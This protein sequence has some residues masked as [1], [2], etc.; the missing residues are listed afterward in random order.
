MILL[1]LLA[2]R[3]AT[4]A[5]AAPPVDKYVLVDAAHAIDAGR[6]DQARLMVARAVRA[7]F[8]G[9][10]VDK[11]VADISFA[12]GKYEDALGQYKALAASHYQQEQVCEKAALS[13]LQLREFSQAQPFA[14]CATASPTA[15]WRSWNARGVI[16][17]SS[18]DWALAAK[19]YER[20]HAL[21]PGRAEIPNNQGWSFVLQGQWSTALPYFQQ[22]AALD[23]G[24]QRIA[25]NL[26]LT[27]AALSADLPKRRTGESSSDW[28]ARLNDAG[29]TAQLRGDRQRAIAA[30]AQAMYASDGWYARAANNLE[31][32]SKP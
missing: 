17:D 30:F 29:V 4:P 22:A 32:A 23:P 15:T 3:A 6:L 12:S 13:A 1:L 10:P 9:P 8:T 16:A 11:L 31:S 5:A 19:C 24:S 14:D 2:A 27:E 20:A 25:D 21:A 7:G 18:G 28:A 26:E